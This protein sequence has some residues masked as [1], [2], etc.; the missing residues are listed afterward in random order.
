MSVVHR[1]ACPCG[2]TWSLFAKTHGDAM[3][4]EFRKHVQSLIDEGEG[5]VGDD[6]DKFD[7][8]K[9][10][11]SAFLATAI[12]A[13][14]EANFVGRV[15][16]IYNHGQPMGVSFLRGLL[17]KEPGKG[18]S[19]IT[20]DGAS[21][22]ASVRHDVSRVF[23]VHG[24]DVEL[25]ETTARF[26][27]KLGLSPII[28]HEQPNS[29]N[30]IIEKFESHADVIFAIVL[31]TPD[32]V[33]AAKDQAQQLKKRARQ[34]VVF[35]FGYFIGHLGRNRVCAL[36]HE[37]VEL[38]SDYSG[39]LYIRVDSEGAWRTKLAQELVQAGLPI[40]LAGLL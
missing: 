24:H 3:N 17:L 38:P 27:H 33:G 36:Y 1:A 37:G 9:G 39:V 4:D 23:I 32:D 26:L 40:E 20:I 34:N 19:T 35:E 13:D 22:Q 10:K 31:L 7:A 15:K 5:L 25:K 8:W 18:K 30:T 12:D 6:E 14:M 11:V 28:L 29:G 16:N 2:L 21:R